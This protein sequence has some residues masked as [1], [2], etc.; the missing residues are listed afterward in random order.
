MCCFYQVSTCRRSSKWRLLVIPNLWNC[1]ICASSSMRFI[2]VVVHH[3]SL[4]FIIFVVHHLCSSPSL[5]SSVISSHT[6]NDLYCVCLVRRV[7]GLWLIFLVHHPWGSSSVVHHHFGSSCLWFVILVGHRCCGSSSLHPCYTELLQPKSTSAIVAVVVVLAAAAAVL[8][9]RE[10]LNL[11]TTGLFPGKDGCA[12]LQETTACP[13]DDQVQSERSVEMRLNPT[14]LSESVRT[15]R[16]G[17]LSPRIRRSWSAYFRTH[18]KTRITALTI[19][20]AKYSWRLLNSLDPRY[21]LTT[22]LNQLCF[23]LGSRGQSSRT[24]IGRVVFAKRTY[25]LP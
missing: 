19:S 12:V 10:L 17:R 21:A 24:P 23:I 8:L 22:L 7:S 25:P 13:T 16:D 1:H 20:T 15:D 4:W 6:N 3:L 5:W 11:A 14:M 18:C 9:L 2:V